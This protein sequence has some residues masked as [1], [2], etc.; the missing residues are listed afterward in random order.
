MNRRSGTFTST[1]YP[2]GTM[3]VLSRLRLL[4]TVIGLSVSLWAPKTG[5]AQVSVTSQH[6]R[7]TLEAIRK[8][9]V[10]ALRQIIPGVA[11]SEQSIR[12]NNPEFAWA[13]ELKKFQAEFRS[14][15]QLE[16]TDGSSPERVRLPIRYRDFTLLLA[17]SQRQ[18]I[19]ETRGRQAWV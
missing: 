16:R 19:L 5:D 10:F 12:L 4:G 11:E 18:E 7:H 14:A 17:Q 13:E 9:D 2:R 15:I 8:A 1:C 3:N 6:V